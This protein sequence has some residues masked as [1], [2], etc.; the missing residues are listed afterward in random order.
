MQRM[1]TRLRVESI[2]ART[3]HVAAA[4]EREYAREAAQDANCKESTVEG[5]AA[6]LALLLASYPNS[7]PCSVELCEPPLEGN[8]V[9]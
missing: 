6:A 7:K 5:M 2:I 9:R 8:D 1:A 3:N 4:R